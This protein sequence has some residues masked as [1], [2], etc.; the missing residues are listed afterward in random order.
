MTPLVLGFWSVLIYGSSD[1]D[2]IFHFPLMI[3]ASITIT[4]WLR[5]TIAI[6]TY[7]NEKLTIRRAPYILPLQINA[8]ETFRIQR[9]P[10]NFFHPGPQIKEGAVWKVLSLIAS[11]PG[12]A[13][14]TMVMALVCEK[15]GT[16]LALPDGFHQTALEKLKSIEQ[17]S[18]FTFVIES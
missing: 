2:F 18:A 8:P 17:M 1:F 11:P 3:I 10:E 12:Y 15:S 7:Q 5:Q 9:M 6:V 4:W 16:I 13:S 14:K